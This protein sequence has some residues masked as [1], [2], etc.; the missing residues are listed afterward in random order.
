MN[1]NDQPVIPP[2]IPADPDP[3]SLRQ[4]PGPKPLSWWL[5]K[6]F[7]CNPFYLVSAALLLYGCY[8]VSIDA[9]MFNLE[10]ARLLFNF[11]SVQAYEALLVVT[12]IFLSR[13][14]IWYD[15]TLLTGLESLFVFVPFILIS[16]ATLT[17]WTM[18]MVMCFG[19]GIAAAMRFGSLKKCFHELNLPRESLIVGGLL[20]AFNILLP[21]VYRIY[22][23]HMNTASLDAGPAHAMNL[24]V[25]MLVLPVMIAQ[26]NGIPQSGAGKGLPQH[27]WLPMGLFL[28]WMIVTGLHLYSL[29]Y[30]Y[31]FGF[32][33]EQ[34]APACLV[35]AWTVFRLVVL[36]FTTMPDLLRRMLMFPPLLVAL[37]AVAPESGNK[38][39]LILT[40]ANVGVYAFLCLYGK[41]R[42]FA[43]H[44]LFVSIS[45]FITG[46]PGTWLHAMDAGST[47]AGIVAFGAM[48]YLM[49]WLTRSRDPRLGI[50]GS[51]ILGVGVLSAFGISTTVFNVAMQSGSVFLLLHSL[52]WHDDEHPGAKIVR[53]LTCLAWVVETF[54]W[55]NCPGSKMWMPCV[56][57][58]VV[59]TAC[60]ARS[61]RQALDHPVIPAASAMVL[62]AGPCD[63]AGSAA[64]SMPVGLLAVIGSF[65]LFGFG[66]V[67][68][69]TRHFWHRHE[70]MS[71]PE[72]IKTPED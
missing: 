39:F 6:L 49:F 62:L 56:P 8:R 59:L 12:A 46:M 48:A 69:L 68:A 42:R 47:H 72:S 24:K 34:I 18:G 32:S 44:L 52:R 70:P 38:T 30:V 10:T 4:Y 19:A 29:G 25:W 23:E 28:L 54:I 61:F 45:M 14:A 27:R 20:L 5:Q 31:Q 26:A 40:V 65:C 37:F 66:T 2:V 63:A 16:Q 11:G 60:L 43:G 36:N 50:L 7:V 57:G 53:V 55:M 17:G 21:L 51:A 35:M 41:N 22:G 58:A 67:V 13:R 71:D 3:G 9:P 33:Y 64:Y 1:E 15:A